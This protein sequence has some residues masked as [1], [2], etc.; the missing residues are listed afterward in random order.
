MRS[1]II[2]ILFLVLG[3][4]E[5]SSQQALVKYDM[6]TRA[7]FREIRTDITD[8]KLSFTIRNKSGKLVDEFEIPK[9]NK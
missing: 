6:E 3:F 7:G 9:K 8:K 4:T 2:I 1:Y 5:V